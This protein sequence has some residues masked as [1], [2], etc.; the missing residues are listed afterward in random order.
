MSINGLSLDEIE[1]WSNESKKGLICG[2]FGCNA[3]VDIRCKYCS[4]GY[5]KEHKKWHSHAVDNSGVLIKE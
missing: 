2:I 4:G 3:P 1:N 5:C